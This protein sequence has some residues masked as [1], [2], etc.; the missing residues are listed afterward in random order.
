MPK[1]TT[2][3]TQT[4]LV[5][6]R[7][8]A[9]IVSCR[10]MPG[11]KLNIATLQEEFGVSLG[12]VREALSQL[13]SEGLILATARR[14]TTV[15]PV[16]RDELL[17]LTRTRVDIESL[18]LQRSIA[19]GDLAWEGR[20]VAAMHTLG[21]IE[22]APAGSRLNDEW[23]RAWVASHLDF[24]STLV[25]ACGSHYLLK[26]RDDL[27]V[28]S[29]RYRRLSLVLGVAKQVRD[30]PDE[31]QRLAEAVLARDAARALELLGAHLMGTA[32]VLLE[33]TDLTL[34]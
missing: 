21:K 19:N 32:N 20:V 17:D 9:D 7:L 28:K 29:E 12:A 4:E 10:L 30:V 23:M 1:P 18:C 8:R 6:E 31:H 22:S 24:H 15:S 25:G 34:E 13:R 26:I 16:S 5:S 3:P 2:S 14:G 33:S 27:S 11:A